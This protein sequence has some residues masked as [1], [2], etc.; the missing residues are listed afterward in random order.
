MGGQFVTS[1]FLQLSDAD[2]GEKRQ[3]T[4]HDAY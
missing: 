4:L 2:F 3:G 1:V